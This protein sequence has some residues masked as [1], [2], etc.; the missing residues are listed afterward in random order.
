MG[1]PKTYDLE[2]LKAIKKSLEG[3][4]ISLTIMCCRSVDVTIQTDVLTDED[5]NLNVKYV[6]GYIENVKKELPSIVN[7]MSNTPNQNR[8][9]LKIIDFYTRNV[10]SMLVRLEMVS[11]KIMVEEERANAKKRGI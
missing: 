5:G 3:E 2:K 7:K 6:K 4:I 8:D 1:Y 10:K 9:T 11:Q